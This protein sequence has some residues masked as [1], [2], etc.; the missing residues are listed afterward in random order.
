MAAF[1]IVFLS[2]SGGGKSPNADDSFISGQAKRP[3]AAPI[4]DTNAVDEDVN[5][6]IADEERVEQ[7]KEEAA[8]DIK[9]AETSELEKEE[10][11]L[12]K[13]TKDLGNS[14]RFGLGSLFG[15]SLTQDEMEQVA[16][17]VEE[18][19][20]SDNHSMLRGKADTIATREIDSI[21]SVALE[22]EEDGLEYT[23]I[24]DDVYEHE[25]GAADTVREDIDT[26]ANRIRDSMSLRAAE[27]EKEILEERLSAKLGKKVKL[28]IVD[29]DIKG[30]EVDG[31]LQ[32]LDNLV[33]GAPSSSSQ[34]STP[35][36]GQGY[37]QQ[38][39]PAYG[40]APPTYG[41]RTPTYGQAPPVSAYGQ[42]PPVYGQATAV[43]PTEATTPTVDTTPS[44]PP[45]VIPP[46]VIE[47]PATTA[48]PPSRGFGSL[49]GWGS[50]KEPEPA[51]TTDDEPEPTTTDDEPEEP[52]EYVEDE[53]VEP[54]VEPEEEPVDSSI[55]DGQTPDEDEE[56][57]Y[58][59]EKDE[60]EDW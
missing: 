10:S 16:E 53:Q 59:P 23:D 39:P 40:Q 28:V 45:P 24:R 3:A 36:Y 49:F 14:I 9:L 34:Y 11:K 29:N 22:D 35:A 44:V 55:Y 37:G 57:V 4:V 27:V 7:V 2:S 50:K 8:D 43:P 52:A 56:V 51:A 20:I 30:A 54:G 32:G 12:D 31:L 5:A 1:L 38:Q 6:A 26:E 58:T 19:L 41:Q 60:D 15:K 42:A 13:D 25:L 33:P 18:K 47:A 21:N 46:P 17:G 48:P